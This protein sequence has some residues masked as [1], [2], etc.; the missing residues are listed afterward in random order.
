[1]SRCTGIFGRTRSDNA[2]IT[3]LKV[4]SSSC[5]KLDLDYARNGEEGANP[6]RCSRGWS[7]K[8]RGTM[9]P[10]APATHNKG[11]TSYD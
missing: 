7:V 9:G 1:M 5:K 10:R 3:G 8:N 11:R 2:Q 6:V 4:I